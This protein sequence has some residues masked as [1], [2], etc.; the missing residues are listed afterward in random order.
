MDDASL[1]VFSLPENILQP[2][3]TASN[4][5]TLEKALKIL[6]D[7]SRSPDG[8]SDLAFKNVLPTVLLLCQNL[9]YPS[10]S[11]LLFL[12]LKLLR[13]LCAGEA[14]NQKS[15]I[16][17]NGV[18]IV[19]HVLN[20]VGFTSDSDYVITRMALQVL[21]NVSLA[22]EDHQ[23]AIWHQFFPLKFVE[24]ARV[25]KRETCD[26]LC[27]VIY[28]CCTGSHELI[29][30]LSGDQGLPV[31]AE[32]L[33]TTSAVG[34]GEDWFKLLLSIICL[35]EN[36]FPQLFS[37]LCPLDNSGNCKSVQ[38]RG[39]FVS[40]QA[41][42]L[43]VLSK[44][45]NER[46]GDVFVSNDFALCVLDLL[47]KATGVVDSVSR[48]K[49]GLPTGSTVVDVL[50]YS[51]TILRDICSCDGL[52]G[53][54]EGGSVD[55]V[56]SLLSSGLLELLLR[57][58]HDLEPPAMIRK[59][60]KQGENQERTT[61][62]AKLCLYEGFRRDIVAVIGNCAYRRKRV[63][64]EIRQRNGILLLL[65]QCVIDEDNPYLREWGIW[66]VRNLL[67]GNAENQKVVAELELQGSVDVPEIAGLGLR[68]EVDE[69][70]RRAKLV[71]V[72]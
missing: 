54:K 12:S 61:Y 64:D 65:Q 58:L 52:G 25:Q 40:E 70:T 2:L 59:A 71:N 46:L 37:K 23:R 63:Q 14:A 20:F 29:D 27:M 22:G 4:S 31:M 56:D 30:G 13:N 66:S 50:G 47:R 35:E 17:E 57:L 9:C 44:I 3:L 28:A 1:P 72:S 32:I 34:F 55:V 45:L 5:S 38:P 53:F 8:R 10:A 19:L 60:M 18:K 16:E 24:I 51:L 7:V 43:N 69:K 33:Q 26:P 48:R 67:E 49:S 15:F 62:S 39:A 36:Q 68:V 21:A 6:I 41:F 11:H 42:L